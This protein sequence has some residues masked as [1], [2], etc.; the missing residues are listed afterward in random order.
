[1]LEIN[2]TD[3]DME[4][5]WPKVRKARGCWLWTAN[6]FGYGYG[7]F[8]VAGRRHP[9]HR[10]LWTHLHGP[11]YQGLYVL[12]SCDNPPCVNPA[13][14][15]LGTHTDNMH[16]MIGKGRF[17]VSRGAARLTQEEAAAI[18]DAYAVAL[19]GGRKYA[20]RGLCGALAERYGVTAGHISRLGHNR[21]PCRA[22]HVHPRHSE[23][24]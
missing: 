17:K 5:F 23:T 10:V 4:R 24:L 16:D 9:A 7:G 21:Q 11:I 1:M 20:P 12:H 2:P 8:S 14:L 18:R 19:A 22:K 13:H 3:K 6:T 15:W